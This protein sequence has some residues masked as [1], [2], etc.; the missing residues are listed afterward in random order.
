MR[1]ARRMIADIGGNRGMSYLPF[2]QTV[3][4]FCGDDAVD[5]YIA[6]EKARIAVEDSERERVALESFRLAIAADPDL[7]Y[8]YGL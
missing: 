7:F 5:A 3:R 2:E 4:Y 8:T 6:A 1:I